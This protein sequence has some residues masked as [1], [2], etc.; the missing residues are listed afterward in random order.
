MSLKPRADKAS[1]AD[2]LEKLKKAAEQV[3]A[4]DATV[5]TFGKFKGQ[6][7][8]KGWDDQSYVQW[9]VSR[10]ARDSQLPNQAAWIDYIEKKVG[11]QEQE[12][13]KTASQNTAASSGE[14]EPSPTKVAEDT[15]VVSRLHTV[16]NATLEMNQR[17]D[18]LE[19]H[20]CSLIQALGLQSDQQQ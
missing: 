6:T 9:C 3:P 10:M 15:S 8:A 11:E 14:P 12:Q 16:E 1:L 18:R 17:L 2:R 20:L 5:F 13:A 19:A 4:E 7:F